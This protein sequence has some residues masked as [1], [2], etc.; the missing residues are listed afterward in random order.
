MGMILLSKILY[1][2]D[3]NKNTY[4]YDIK[5]DTIIYHF[6]VNE[7]SNVTV[8]MLQ[9]NV[10]LYYY[11][12]AINYQDN[13]FKIRVNH[14]SSNTSSYVVNHAVNVD[15]SK[16]TLEVDGVVPKESSK[17][18]CNQDNAI[19][20]LKNGQSTI[21]PNLLIDNFDVDSNH[22]AYIGKFRDEVMFYLLSRGIRLEVANKLLIKSFLLNTDS[23][24]KSKIAIFEQ[25]ID[26]IGG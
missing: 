9:K 22:S 7:S 21:K 6:V 2:L 17:C 16:F 25:E 19:I 23:I 24:D 3:R 18:I 8:N 12:S 11:F 10:K 14:L 20:N 13:Y 1:I 15:A 4:T 5:E 26:K